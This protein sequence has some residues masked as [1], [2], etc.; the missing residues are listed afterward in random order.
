MALSPFNDEEDLPMC[1][2]GDFV[3][4]IIHTDERESINRR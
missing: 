3:L 1:T 2:Y 4:S